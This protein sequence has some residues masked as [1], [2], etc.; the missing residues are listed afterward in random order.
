MTPT[1]PSATWKWIRW[2]M[3]VAIA[4]ETESLAGMSSISIVSSISGELFEVVSDDFTG[5]DLGSH[6]RSLITVV[7]TAARRKWMLTFLNKARSGEA[8]ERV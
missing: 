5:L 1:S 4:N 7:P 6:I 3:E 2:D 8:V